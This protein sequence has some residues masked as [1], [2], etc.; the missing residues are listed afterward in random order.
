M[1]LL[2]KA[3]QG[4]AL[5]RPDER[6]GRER[7]ELAD[8]VLR[9]GPRAIGACQPLTHG[10]ERRQRRRVSRCDPET[11]RGA[12]IGAPGESPWKPEWQPQEP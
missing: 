3:E 7:N 12:R 2:Q 9:T 4:V 10:R 5:H 6:M 1:V 11:Q 8:Q